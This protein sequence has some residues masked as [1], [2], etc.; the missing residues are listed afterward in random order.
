MTDG[1]VFF[2]TNTSGRGC[3][4]LRLEEQNEKGW[5]SYSLAA[6]LIFRNGAWHRLGESFP[7][8]VVESEIYPHAS[9]FWPLDHDGNRMEGKVDAELA[10]VALRDATDVNVPYALG[11]SLDDWHVTTCGEGLAGLIWGYAPGDQAALLFDRDG[12]LHSRYPSRY[13]K[14]PTEIR[15]RDRRRKNVSDRLDALA[16]QYAPIEVPLLEEFKSTTEPLKAYHGQLPQKVRKVESFARNTRRRAA[17]N[18]IDAFDWWLNGYPGDAPSDEEVYAAY[19]KSVEHEAERTRASIAALAKTTVSR[20]SQMAEAITDLGPLIATGIARSR[21]KMKPAVLS[22]GKLDGTLRGTKL[23]GQ[24]HWAQND[25]RKAAGVSH[26]AIQRSDEIPQVL[27]LNACYSICSDLDKRFDTTCQVDIDVSFYR[28]H[29]RALQPARGRW[30]RNSA[31]AFY[32]YYAH[33][34]LAW[35]HSDEYRRLLAREQ[36]TTEQSSKPKP[37]ARYKTSATP[38][39]TRAAGQL[40]IMTSSK[41]SHGYH[42]FLSEVD[43][44][45]VP[46]EVISLGQRE[47]AI[48]AHLRQRSFKDGDII[49]IVRGGGDLLHPSF[50]PFDHFDSAIQLKALSERGVIVVTGIGHSRDSFVVERGATFVE[51]TPV[52]AGQRVHELLQSI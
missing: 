15:D 51:S 44:T 1:A 27:D 37:A 16:K 31:G 18:A 14:S 20:L 9:D 30:I 22:A 32:R 29:S 8:I 33:D 40:T 7:D 42:D 24:W 35:F 26:L 46:H 21:Y 4:L 39:V 47:N 12:A 13:G 28:I 38:A 36:R 52:K 11:E 34:V 25:I 41:E 5:R 43:L 23:H 2:S 10:T 19:V 49:C 50:K 6:F 48:L 3:F 45:D 17:S